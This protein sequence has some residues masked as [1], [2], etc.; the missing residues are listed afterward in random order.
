MSF[1]SVHQQ[2]NTNEHTHSD[3]CDGTYHL[4]IQFLYGAGLGD[5]TLF[6]ILQCG[7]FVVISECASCIQRLRICSGCALRNR[8]AVSVRPAMLIVAYGTVVQLYID[9]EIVIGQT[10]L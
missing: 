9:G 3:Y 1:T 7:R 4:H 8:Y 10:G 5:H 6:E 2:E